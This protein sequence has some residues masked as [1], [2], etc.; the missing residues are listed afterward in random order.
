[1]TA[2]HDPVLSRVKLDSTGW[3]GG[4]LTVRYYSRKAGASTWVTTVRGADAVPVSS[5]TAVTAYD[6]EFPWSGTGAGTV[7]YAVYSAATGTW[8]YALATAVDI[9]AQAWLKVVGYPYLNRQIN[10]DGIGDVERNGRGIGIDIIG[11]GPASGTVDVMSGRSLPVSIPTTTWAERVAF[12]TM[13][14]VGGV[15]YLHCDEEDLGVRSMY[16]VVQRSTESRR[17]RVHGVK[18]RFELQLE[19][20]ARPH[21]A[22]AGAVGTYQSV[23][24]QNATYTVVLA[25]YPT[26]LDLAQIAGSAADVIVS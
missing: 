7:D 11:Q 2:V 5:G 15:L 25:A 1:M 26:Y 13:L 17:G 20:R 6:Y 24:S 12:D 8:A 16:A 21:Y 18:A 19:E 22:Y 14:S 23:L 4:D 3:A 10:P 9:T